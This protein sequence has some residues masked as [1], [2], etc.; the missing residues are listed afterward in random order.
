MV[1]QSCKIYVKMF[2]YKYVN[3]MNKY[4]SKELRLM[5]YFMAKKIKRIQE[6]FNLTAFIYRFV[7]MYSIWGLIK[8]FVGEWYISKPG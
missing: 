2:S 7:F 4:L 6:H 8:K 5:F 3:I 1:M